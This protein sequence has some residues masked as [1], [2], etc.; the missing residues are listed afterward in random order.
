MDGSKSIPNANTDFHMSLKNLNKST[1][2]MERAAYNHLISYA[3]ILRKREI[4]QEEDWFNLK[5]TE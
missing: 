4:V 5:N 1:T 2:Y 3:K